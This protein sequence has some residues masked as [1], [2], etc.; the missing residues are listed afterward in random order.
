V[1]FDDPFGSLKD[2]VIIDPQWLADVMKSVVSFNNKW[3]KNGLVSESDLRQWVWRDYPP[4]LHSSLQ[5]IF[6]RFQARAT[7]PTAR[8]HARTHAHFPTTT[9]PLPATTG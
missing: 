2:L 6:E 3:I 9:D 8:T 5:R 4:E 1:H 7:T